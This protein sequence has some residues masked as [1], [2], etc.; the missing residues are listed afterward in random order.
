MHLK[1]T[2]LAMATAL[3][4]AA[5]G[6][7][8][9]DPPYTSLVSFGDSLSD[10][11]SY[12]TPGLLAV[13]GGKG[14]KYTVNGAADGVWVEQLAAR[15]DLPA[16]CAAMTG[17]EATGD[18]AAL[19]AP[20]TSHTECTA[21]G[22][23]GSRVVDPV[24]PWNKALLTQSSIP[25]V[26]FTGQLGQLTVPVVTQIANHLTAHGGSFTGKEL[27][28][29]L[30]GAN[31]VFFNID[32][33]ADGTQAPETAGTN[34]ATAGA[35]LA[36]LIKAELLAKGAKRVVV[37]NLPNISNTPASRAA[38]P[39]GQALVDQ[40]TKAFNAQLAAGL[41]GTEANVL[42]VDLY[43]ENTA[44]ATDPARFGLS[45]VTTPACTNTFPNAPEGFLAPS[46]TCTVD[47][48]RPDS[49]RFLFADTV[50]P[51]PYGHSL[52]RDMTLTALKA[53]NWL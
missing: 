24:G 46:L 30:A 41:A 18:F 34:V 44:H 10:V 47:T 31:D 16:P 14:G 19:A 8:D 2:C 25:E 52:L 5:C 22:Q 33:V 50:H 11:G 37:L 12:R 28:T 36:N 51:T 20:V 39:T 29:V 26:Q 6:G 9:D 43:A 13:S 32:R 48:V 15:L 42:Q 53:K 27:I 38:G 35:Q 4:L 7:G 49:S 1:K 21:Y 3:V 40:M 23:G 17:L 45:N